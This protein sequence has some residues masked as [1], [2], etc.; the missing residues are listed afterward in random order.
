MDTYGSDAGMAAVGV[1]FMLVMMAIGLAFYLFFGYCMKLIAEKTGH[2]ENS[3]WA[4]VPIL[5]I[6]LLLQIAQKPVWWI[7]LLIIP[8]VGTVISI[9][10]FMEIA[11]ARGKE[12]WWGII[13]A[14]VP[15]IGLPYL[16]FSDDT[17]LA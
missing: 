14:I 7:I 10:V 13:T 1:G 11:Q 12:S 2:T 4:W 15:F 5:Q 16:A 17:A 6:V 3:W 8:L 9:L